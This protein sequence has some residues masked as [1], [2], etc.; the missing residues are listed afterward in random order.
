MSEQIDIFDAN[1]KK[2][3]V[4]DRLSAHMQGAW[5]RTFHLW[6][7][8][9]EYKG[10]LLF[11][12]RSPVAKNYPNLLDITA[13][14]HLRTGEELSDG[15]REVSEELGITV[16]SSDLK[17]LG[18]RVEVADQENG[19]LNRE[20]QGVFMLRDD[21]PLESYRPDP[22][23][24]HGLLALPV[25]AGMKLFEEKLEI[26]RVNGIRYDAKAH[27]WISCVEEITKNRFLPR[28]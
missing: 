14:G 26:I 22:N 11:Q 20:Y 7:V 6:V 17:W 2:T 4:A 1:L 5:H 3:G 27:V 28:I 9:G 24:V 19:Q 12:L 23:E 13:A 16:R 25:S 18:Y 10:S 15:I 21:R 8:T